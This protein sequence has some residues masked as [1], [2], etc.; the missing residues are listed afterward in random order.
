MGYI[1][2][3]QG[4]KL[5]QKLNNDVNHPYILGYDGTGTDPVYAYLQ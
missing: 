1:V 2:C 3:W 4:L 5:Q